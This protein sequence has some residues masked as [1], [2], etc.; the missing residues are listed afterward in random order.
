[1]GAANRV[2][3]KTRSPR[4]MVVEDDQLMRDAI[5]EALEDEDCEVLALGDG[6]EVDEAVRTFR[7]DLAILDVGLP[8][9]LD[10]HAVARRLRAISDVPFMFVTAAAQIEDLLAGFDVGADDYVTKPFVMSELIARVRA[11]LRRADWLS[12]SVWTVGDIVIDEDAH[13]VVVRGSV[14]DLTAIE[15]SLLFALA[16]RPG[17][18]ISKVQLLT[19]VWGFDHYALNLVEVHMSALRHKIEAHSPRVVHTV[20]NVGYVLRA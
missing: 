10:G 2:Q 7:P 8:N 11:V 14:V 6:D 4:V 5:M 9:Q 18:V 17:R 19:E 1:M 16:R 15:F 12:R 20:R 13:T 3:Q